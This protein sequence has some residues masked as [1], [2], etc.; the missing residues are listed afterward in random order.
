MNDN[1]ILTYKYFTL[2]LCNP[3][4]LVLNEK[5]NKIGTQFVDIATGDFVNDM[6]KMR[7]LE[8]SSDAEEITKDE[9]DKMVE[10]LLRAKD[11]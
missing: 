2:G 5:G 9:F 7:R 6:D 4:R 10:D 1:R 3:I 8:L 11:Q